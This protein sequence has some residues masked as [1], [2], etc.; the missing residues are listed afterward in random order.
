MT[1]NEIEK[2]TRIPI[3]DQNRQLRL[4]ARV[5]LEAKLRI[6]K[7]QNSKFHKL[8][9][10]NSDIDNAILTLASLI[11]AIIEEVNSMT[12]ADLNV[13]LFHVKN[14]KSRAKREKLL[15]YWSVVKTLKNDKSMSFREIS[16]YLKKH[17]KFEVAYSTIFKVW[18][19]LEKIKGEK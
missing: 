4:F 12:S 11:L 17:H 14:K 2:L 15:M 18:N 8:K 6:I 7:I 19:E 9:S 10:V 1:I 3:D 16:Y 5:G 13:S